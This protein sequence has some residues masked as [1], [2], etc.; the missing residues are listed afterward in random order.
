MV[1]PMRKFRTPTLLL[2]VATASLSI[3]PIR[4]A[5]Q[6]ACYTGLAVVKQ[7][8]HHT[9]KTLH[10]WKAWGDAHPNYHPPVHSWNA[11][12]RVAMLKRLN[13]ACAPVQLVPSDTTAMVETDDDPV[14]SDLAFSV[15]PDVLASTGSTSGA[16]QDEVTDTG[17]SG[18]GFAGITGFSTPGPVGGVP[19]AP[20]IL[21]TPEPSTWLLLATGMVGIFMFAPR[22]VKA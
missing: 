19:S 18:P 17:E 13:I 3:A 22:R 12:Q 8:I 5:A 14:L 9:A 1:S 11:G 2:T 15:E 4:G 6:E 10:A 16:A 20:P 21:P 7:H